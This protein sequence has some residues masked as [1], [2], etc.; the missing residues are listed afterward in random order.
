MSVEGEGLC[1]RA[2]SV[3]LGQV[4]VEVAG[5]GVLMSEPH[6]CSDKPEA[7]GFRDTTLILC[8]CLSECS[9]CVTPVCNRT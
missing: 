9:M 3:R 6:D 5:E 4:A 8:V 1:V 2:G 7:C